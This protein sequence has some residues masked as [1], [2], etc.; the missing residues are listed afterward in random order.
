MALTAEDLWPLVEKLPRG[1]RVRL[2][3][4]ALSRVEL[5]PGATD[6]QRYVAWPPRPDEFHSDTAGDPLAWEGDDWEEFG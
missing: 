1:E 3:R 6:A 4:F 5:P 2:A